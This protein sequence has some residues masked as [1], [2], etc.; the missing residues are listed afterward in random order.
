MPPPPPPAPPPAPTGLPKVPKTKTN[1]GGATDRKALLTSIH[2]GAKLKKTV[3]NDRSAPSVGNNNKRSDPPG[4][5]IGGGSTGGGSTPSGNSAGP[6]GLGGLFAGGIPKLPNKGNTGPPKR[7]GG[8]SVPFKPP[9]GH[10]NG[11]LVNGTTAAPPPPPPSQSSKPSRP[12][13]N[14]NKKRENFENERNLEHKNSTVSS[15]TAQWNK[16]KVQPPPPPSRPAPSHSS[17]RPT[18]MV[19]RPL[20]PT[21]HNLAE[22]SAPP[23]PPRSA[24]P[25][26]PRQTPSIPPGRPSAPPPPVRTTSAQGGGTVGRSGGVRPQ[27]ARRQDP[28]PPPPPHSG[29]SHSFSS[30]HA[31]V[32]N[33]HSTSITSNN[34]NNFDDRFKF[35]SVHEF[36]HPERLN[37]GVKT[38]PSHS[39][40]RASTQQ[41][42]APPPPPPPR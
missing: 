41:R 2:S 4:G 18:S 9:G 11:K 39:P 34:S 38:Y 28:P 27:L 42:R 6:V 3:T 40:R 19:G 31:P 10:S 7:V 21:P 13:S 14:I 23:G 20:P 35:H 30:Q 15:N 29:H 32:L 22:S 36:P 12:V 1:A 26:P 25:P 17:S 16:A 8:P 33:K 37:I 24:P 5:G